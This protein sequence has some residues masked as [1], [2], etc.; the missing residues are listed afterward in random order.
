MRKFFLL[1]LLGFFSI[2]F[3]QSL[4]I[5]LPNGLTIIACRRETKQLV[6][7]VAIIRGGSGVEK[8]AG[9][10]NLLL[11]LMPLGTRNYDKDEIAKILE[12]DLIDMQTEININYWAFYLFCPAK[13]LEQA[14]H[15]LR[16]IL[17]YPLFDEYE[18]EKEKKKAILESEEVSAQPFVKAYACLRGIIYGD[19]DPYGRLING[20]KKSLEKLN[21]E[22]LRFLHLTYFHPQNLFLSIVG[23]V[24]PDATIKIAEGIFGPLP[25]GDRIS[26]SYPFY[27][28]LVRPEAEVISIPSPFAYLLI[29]LPLP[30]INHTD[31]PILQVI[32]TLLGEGTS[33]RLAR[34]LRWRMGISYELGA[35]YPPL[36]GKSHLL[37]WATIDP[38][39]VEEAREAII[40]ELTSLENVDEQELEKAK[41]KLLGNY[42]ITIASIKEQAFRMAFFEAIGLG[43]QYMVEFPKIIGKIT[44]ADVKRVIRRYIKGNTA[45]VL[46]MPSS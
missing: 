13:S 25:K 37:L 40:N 22:E 15:L 16:E 21:I 5:K 12:D 20:T 11:K 39:R 31:Y 33:S 45:L 3:S 30:G 38:G 14:L 28:P 23:D 6:S 27:R 19:T 24:D 17:F 43:Y 36:I 35:L 26:F 7:I 32:A 10:G 2:S 4:R 41:N 1:L 46:I 29:G 9:A 44:L 34:A 42:I 18:F 8:T